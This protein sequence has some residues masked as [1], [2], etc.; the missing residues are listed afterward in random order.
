MLYGAVLRSGSGLAASL[1]RNQELRVQTTVV[2]GFTWASPLEDGPSFDVVTVMMTSKN[3]FSASYR[4][5]AKAQEL[6]SQCEREIFRS[7]HQLTAEDLSSLQSLRAIATT[8]LRQLIDEFGFE[9]ARLHPHIATP[10]S[11][12]LQPPGY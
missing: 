4:R 10:P 3:A 7:G 5:W 11:E 12:Q 6:V 9:V 1:S 2:G 8:R